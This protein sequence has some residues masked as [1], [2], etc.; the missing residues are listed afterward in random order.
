MS[1]FKVGQIV[2][3]IRSRSGLVREGAIGE[4]LP[5]PASLGVG[6]EAVDFHG[7]VAPNNGYWS[8]RHSDRIPIN[9]P[10]IDIGTED[11]VKMS[12]KKPVEDLV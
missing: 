6:S 5:P 11:V 9:Y 1:K 3:L 7:F 8:T 2:M 4:I 12:D 10:D